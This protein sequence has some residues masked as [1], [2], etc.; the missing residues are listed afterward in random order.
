MAQG[1][2]ISDTN[3]AYPSFGTNTVTPNQI[4]L[5]GD[6]NLGFPDP[7]N[8]T[9]TGYATSIGLSASEDVLMRAICANCKDDWD[10]Q[11]TAPAINDF[12][13]TKFGMATLGVDGG[14]IVAT[15]SNR[16]KIRLR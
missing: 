14:E 12:M 8:A 11:L 2:T 13:R 10:Y 15:G 5:D 6:N 16:P 7:N 9:L 3:P 4:D 1:I